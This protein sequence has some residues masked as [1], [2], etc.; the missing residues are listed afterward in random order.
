MKLVK[1]IYFKRVPFKRVQL[2][3]ILEFASLSPRLINYF[4]I[5][6]I[7]IQIKETAI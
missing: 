7:K 6:I 5:L 3:Y 4:Y 2:R 1:P